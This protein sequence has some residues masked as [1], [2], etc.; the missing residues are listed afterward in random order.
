MSFSFGIK[1]ATKADAITQ[2]VAKMD[3]V[4]ASQDK[5]S[6]DAKLVKATVEAYVGLLGDDESKDVAL[7]VSGWLSW[8]VAHTTAANISVT[9]SLV[10][11]AS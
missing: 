7:S 4:V 9:A 8:S 5:H 10:D 6:G 11:R 3:E 2:A 1:A